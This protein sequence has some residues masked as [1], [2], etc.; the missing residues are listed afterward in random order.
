MHR[1]LLTLLALLSLFAVTTPAQA[2]VR[3]GVDAWRSGKWSVAVAEWQAAAANGDRDAEFNLAQAYRLGFGVSLDLDHRRVVISF[4]DHFV[5]HQ[6]IA[7]FGECQFGR[8]S[9]L[10]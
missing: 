5:G 6:L 9:P 3:A 1:R 4:G 8:F 7:V 10:A 2:S